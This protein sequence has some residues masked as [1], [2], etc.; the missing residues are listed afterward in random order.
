MA[1]NNHFFL[2]QEIAYNPIYPQDLRSEAEFLRSKIFHPREMFA[3]S[4]N[5]LMTSL[6]EH[7]KLIEQYRNFVMKALPVY[8]KIMNDIDVQRYGKL[9]DITIEQW[10]E[11]AQETVRGVLSAR[12]KKNEPVKDQ[13]YLFKFYTSDKDSNETIMVQLDFKDMILNNGEVSKTFFRVNL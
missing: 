3:F 10:I 2:L 1:R 11:T 8:K 12:T 9:P 5:A 7:Q 4:L 13:D 6:D